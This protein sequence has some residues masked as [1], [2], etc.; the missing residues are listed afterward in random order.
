MGDNFSKAPTNT[1]RMARWK[2]Q[3]GQLHEIFRVRRPFR[4]EAEAP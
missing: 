1:T 2:K 3:G 4:R